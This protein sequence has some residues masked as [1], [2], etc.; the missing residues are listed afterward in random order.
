MKAT[1]I[2]PVTE[3]RPVE[4]APAKV[5]LE[6]SLEEA[7]FLTAILGRVTRSVDS[8]GLYQDLY[9]RVVRLNPEPESAQKYNALNRSLTGTISLKQWEMA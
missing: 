3:N 6:L 8:H 7:R 9:H 5:Q 2:P 1:V 4:V